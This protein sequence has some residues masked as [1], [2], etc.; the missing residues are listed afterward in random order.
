MRKSVPIAL[1]FMVLIIAGCSHVPAG[2]APSTSPL[3][4]GEA[5]VIGHAVGSASYFSLV[6]IIPFGKPDYD[7]AIGDAISQVP[8]GQ[9]L[10]NVRSWF[11]STY[12]IIGFV[13]TLS[14]EGDV[15]K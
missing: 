7:A 4:L 1:M 5:T 2:L 14:V 6:G 3:Q 15:V 12:V 13:H 10:I 8:G 11:S 9:K